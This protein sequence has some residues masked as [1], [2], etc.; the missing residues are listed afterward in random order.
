MMRLIFMQKKTTT[1]FL[2]LNAGNFMH[3]AK[4]VFFF[5]LL[6]LLFSIPVR[7]LIVYNY[8]IVVNYQVLG[9]GFYFSTSCSLVHNFARPSFH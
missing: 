1:M 4:R 6:L 3:T 8:L 2:I 9:G 7:L 5:P